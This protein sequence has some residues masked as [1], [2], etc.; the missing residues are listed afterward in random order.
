MHNQDHDAYQLQHST[1]VEE[2]KAS[3][4]V[5]RAFALR[6]RQA[7]LAELIAKNDKSKRRHAMIG[8]AAVVIVLVLIMVFLLSTKAN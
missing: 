5:S 7:T 4:A 2:M 3:D 6:E 8:E 1:A